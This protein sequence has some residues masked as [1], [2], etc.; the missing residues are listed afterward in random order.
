METESNKACW[1]PKL[2]KLIG[3]THV[4]LHV[5]I[6]LRPSCRKLEARVFQKCL[7]NTYMQIST[8]IIIVYCVASLYNMNTLD[9]HNSE[10]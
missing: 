5:A 10:C 1:S 3:H 9:L 8:F 7:V 2:Q 4:G 6:S